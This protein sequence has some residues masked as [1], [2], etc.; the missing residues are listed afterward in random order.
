[1]RGWR[2]WT[3]PFVILGVNA[4]TLFVLSGAIAKTMGLI[5]VTNA[6]GKAVSVHAYIYSTWYAPLAAPKNAS[7]LFALT[8]LACLFGVLWIMYRRRIFL[9]A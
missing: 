5:T 3:T 1:V 7:L 6:A 8:H 9:R 4:I 2:W